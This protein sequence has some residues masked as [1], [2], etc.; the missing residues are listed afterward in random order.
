MKIK[1]DTIEISIPTPDGEAVAERIPVEVALRWDD[2]LNEW[3]LTEEAHRVI[4]DTKSRYMGLLL[5]R[6]LKELRKRLGFSQ[7][8]MGELFQ[9]GEKSWTR[10]ETG[11]HR[12]SRSINLLIRAL[13]EREISIGY[14]LRMAGKLPTDTT[15]RESAIKDWKHI[16]R[17]SEIFAPEQTSPSGLSSIVAFGDQQ[18]RWSVGVEGCTSHRAYFAHA[19]RRIYRMDPKT[20]R[21]RIPLQSLER[22][23]LSSCS[24]G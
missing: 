5:P 14:L 19:R 7:K 17:I 22:Q 23:S 2:E 6:Q 16:G 21:Q 24:L 3:L 9:V 10:W 4:D 20:H 12:P 1:R 18:T 8:D 11:K 13:Y 15:H